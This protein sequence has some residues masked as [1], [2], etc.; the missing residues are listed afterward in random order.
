MTG[1][2]FSLFCALSGPYCAIGQT[3]LNFMNIFLLHFLH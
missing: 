1:L 3:K 2:P